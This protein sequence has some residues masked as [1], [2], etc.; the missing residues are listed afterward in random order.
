MRARLIGEMVWVAL[1]AIWAN[2]LRS[3]LTIL[4]N[5]VAIASIMTLVSLIEGINDE[6][7][8]VIVSEVGA[9]SFTIERV[10]LVA[11]FN[12]IRETRSNPR[13]TLDDQAALR[14]LG[15]N[16][17]AVIAQGQQRGEVR[18]RNEVL[19]SVS[20]QGVTREFSRFPTFDAEHGRLMTPSEVSRRQN[21]AL[22]GSDLAERLFGGAD[23]LDR[24]IKV[25]GVHFR[26]VGV[27][28]PKGS[29]FG[30]SQDEFVVVPLGAFQRLFGTRQSLTLMVRPTDPSE[31]ERAMDEARVALRV[32]RRLRPN[33]ENNFGMFTSDT[34]LDI[35]NQATQGIFAVLVGVVGLAL[36]VAGIVIMNIMLMAVSERTR[37]IG[38]R[39]ALGAK[40]RDVMWQMLSESVVL[41]LLGGVL[42]TLVGVMAALALDRYAPV[43][44]SVHPWSVLLAIG[45]TAFVGLFFGL[46]PAARAAALDPID[47][48]G[49]GE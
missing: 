37:E 31:I 26:V 33:E 45:M 15:G 35:Y 21:V 19:E 49:R 5:V 23:P 32:E 36:V 43:P 34:I 1:S 3:F 40:R 16:F 39:K 14:R 42:G 4:G 41:S 8:N 10:G 20:I 29:M 11:S 47:A 7:A 24:V 9:D 46:Y 12:D 17:E 38:L 48:L 6:V 13:I 25:Q 22:L 27:S 18:Y 44:A 2:K 30:R 28:R